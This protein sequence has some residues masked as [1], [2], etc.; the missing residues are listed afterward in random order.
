VRRKP[1]KHPERATDEAADS[2]TL[3][4]NVHQ[5]EPVIFTNMHRHG[6]CG[7]L[8][9]FP[10]HDKMAGDQSQKIAYPSGFD[11]SNKL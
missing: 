10:Y 7:Y 2:P 5:L 3:S 6:S 8:Y 9:R 1:Q 4:R 11:K